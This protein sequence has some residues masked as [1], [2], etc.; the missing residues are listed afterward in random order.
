MVRYL[1]KEKEMVLLNELF[2]ILYQNMESVVPFEGEFRKE[3]A[4]WIACVGAALKRPPRQI[5]LLYAGETLAGFCMYYVNGGTMMVEEVQIS[6]DYQKTLHAA[7]LFRF[8]RDNLMP[9]VHWLEAY[10]DYRNISSQQLMR[11]LGMEQIG[12]DGRFLHF[13]MNTVVL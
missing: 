13:R 7:E 1:D 3:K 6:F 8:I 9:Q 10:A 5:L 11:K 12:N 2:D 4:E